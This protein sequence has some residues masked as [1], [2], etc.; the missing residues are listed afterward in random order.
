MAGRGARWL[1]LLSR[2]GASSTAAIELLK[3]LDDTGVHVQTPCCDISDTAALEKALAQSLSNM[4]PIVGCIQASMVLQ[5]CIQYTH[6][7]YILTILQDGLFEEMSFSQWE[8]ALKSKVAGS[9][10]LHTLLPDQLDF[11]ILLSSVSGIIG[12]HGQSNYAAGNTYL[13]ALAHYRVARGQKAVSIDLGAMVSDGYLADNKEVMDRLLSQGSMLPISR[14][15]LNALLDYYCDPSLDTLSLL[16]C[17][18]VVGIN[19]PQRIRA[20][21]CDDPSWLHYPIF[22]TMHHLPGSD[23]QTGVTSSKRDFRDEFL[24]AST[25]TG[26][27]AI[28]ADALVAKLSRSLSSISADVDL[29]TPIHSYGVDSLLAVE[30]RSWIANQFQ[31]DVPIFEILSGTSFATLGVTVASKSSQKKRE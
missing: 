7:L 20:M 8:A 12:N 10:N 24:K 29:R 9:W 19:T 25:L 23:T 13:D 3:E 21:G 16:E 17:Q 27:G 30:L 14:D 4:P 2:S 5:V 1:I 22:R 15:N 6:G 18:A 31:A 28:V 11:F 26:A